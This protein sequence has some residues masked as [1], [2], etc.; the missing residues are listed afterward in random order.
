MVSIPKPVSKAK[1]AEIIGKSPAAVTQ[2]LNGVIDF[3]LTEV[4]AIVQFFKEYFPDIT[5]EK[6]FAQAVTI[7]TEAKGA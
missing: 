6:I 3:K 7:V 1:L 4:I 5:A 2:K